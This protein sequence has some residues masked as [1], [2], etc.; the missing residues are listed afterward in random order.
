[1]QVV[2][3]NDVLQHEKQHLNDPYENVVKLQHCNVPVWQS[4]QTA[5]TFVLQKTGGLI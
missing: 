3:C 2:F 1:M 4:K 5:D